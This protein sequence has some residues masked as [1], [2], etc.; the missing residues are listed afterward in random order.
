MFGDPLR[1]HRNGL[2]A[3][4][5]LDAA[6]ELVASAL[7]AQPDEIVFTSGGTESVALAI[8]G[9]VRPVREIGHRIVTTTVEHPAVGGVLHT[10]ETDG[11]ESELV[12][13]DEHGRVDVDAFGVPFAGPGDAPRLGPA[14]QP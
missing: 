1:L 2:A 14:R 10:L 9:G 8:W 7:G 3:R 12:G 11:F 5:L 4:R 6:R 13:V